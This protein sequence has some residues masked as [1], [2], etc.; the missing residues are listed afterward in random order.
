MLLH[1]CNYQNEPLFTLF[2][3]KE[4]VVYYP[5]RYLEWLRRCKRPIESQKQTANAIKNHCEWLEKSP[6][7]QGLTVDEALSITA[8]DD[9][10]EWISD[11]RDTGIQENTVN[12]REVLVKG[13]YKWFTTDEGSFRKDIPW[14][15]YNY[16]RKTHKKLPRFLTPQQVIKLLQGFHNESQ[17]V[18]THFMF[19]TGVRIS[20]L[21]R[22]TRRYLP[23]PNNY[24]EE[25]NYYPLRV[26][27][28]KSSSKNTFKMR[29][30]IISRPMLARIR[31]Y[32]STSEYMLAKDW[33]MYDPDKPIFLN[34]NNKA[35]SKQSVYDGIKAS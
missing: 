16:T 12:N 7:F 4:K 19:D 31:R 23:D 18:A 21:I 27:G 26:P 14:T 2:D 22:I 25:F 5:T 32:H 28:S 11:E 30:T 3:S 10:F 24:P 6:F 33:K 1:K 15:S 34:V 35:L 8:G 20:E 9:I 17:R 13:M 29:D